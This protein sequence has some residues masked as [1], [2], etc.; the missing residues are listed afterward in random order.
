MRTDAADTGI[1]AGMYLLTDSGPGGL[2]F[3]YAAITESAIPAA[4]RTLARTIRAI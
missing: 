4:V 3:G 1:S 2:L